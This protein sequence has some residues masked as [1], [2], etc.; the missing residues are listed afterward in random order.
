VPIVFD[1]TLGEEP[2]ALPT[3]PGAMPNTVGAL[4]TRPR[5]VR[6]PS[7]TT[8]SIAPERALLRQQAQDAVH[9]SWPGVVFTDGDVTEPTPAE[10]GIPGATTAPDEDGWVTLGQKPEKPEAPKV[11]APKE[12][13]G[14]F[15]NLL[16]KT[17]D[18]AGRV[19]SDMTIQTADTLGDYAPNLDAGLIIDSNGVHWA[20]G[21][22]YRDQSFVHGVASALRDPDYQFVDHE[23]HVKWEDI[24]AAK[25]NGDYGAMAK[26]AGLYAV[27]NGISSVPDM[28]AVL[29]N[30]PGYFLGLASRRT[31][32]RAQNAG[33]P[34]APNASDLAI[35]SST[36]IVETLLE[37]YGAE[38][39]FDMFK[40]PKSR[41][42]KWIEGT[43][44]ETFTEAAQ[45]TAEEIGTKVG[46]PKQ[47][48][49]A[50]HLGEVAAQNALGGFGGGATIGG[51]VQL[52]DK[53]FGPSEQDV[54][55]Q[56][57]PAQKTNTNPQAPAATGTPASQQ[58]A[59]PTT[60]AP[61]APASPQ[62]A[63]P[64]LQPGTVTLYQPEGASGATPVRIERI[65][66]KT[67]QAVVTSLDENGDP[68]IVDGEPATYVVQLADLG[69]PKTT[70][71][72]AAPQV[73]PAAP[74]A[75]AAPVAPPAAP[76]APTAAP[77][78]GPT[79][80]DG[81]P[82]V[83]SAEPLIDLKGQIA[84]M[85]DPNTPRK[86]VLLSKDNVD[87]LKKTKLLDQ[88]TAGTVPVVNFDYRGGTMLF[89][90]QATAEAAVAARDA[91]RKGT[92]IQQLIGQLTGA[93]INKPNAGTPTAV[94]QRVNPQ[95][96]VVQESVVPTGAVP[97]T[98]TAMAQPGHA[99]VVTTPEAALAR[100]AQG[101]AADNA[102]APTAPAP[103]APAPLKAKAP[104]A[105]HQAL[106]D[107]MA[108]TAS[109]EVPEANR[110]N[111]GS[112][113][114]RQAN[115]VG[116][117]LAVETALKHAVAAGVLSDEEV[118]AAQAAVHDIKAL[119]DKSTEATEKGQGT[120]HAKVTSKMKAL[121]ASAQT[122]AA[123][124][125][126]KQKEAETAPKKAD[127]KPP[128]AAAKKKKAAPKVEAETKAEEKAETE[129][130]DEDINVGGG[131]TRKLSDLART[132]ATA[133]SRG[134]LKASPHK[135]SSHL[136]VSFADAQKVLERAKTVTK[137]KKAEAKA[138]ETKKAVEAVKPDP[139]A[140]APTTITIAPRKV[141]GAELKAFLKEL[142]LDPEQI[143]ADAE[144][145][146]GSKRAA[147]GALARELEKYLPG[148]TKEGSW[149]QRMAG[150]RTTEDLTDAQKA[151]I[152]KAVKDFIGTEN[153]TEAM[154][155]LIN[156]MQ[157]LNLDMKTVEAIGQYAQFMKAFDKLREKTDESAD[158]DG[159]SAVR[160]I[161]YAGN[162][163]LDLDKP[164]HNIDEPLVGGIPRSVRNR[165][166]DYR[167]QLTRVLRGSSLAQNIMRNYMGRNRVMS[168]KELLRDLKNL[169]P[170]D[171]YFG[172]LISRLLKA[173]PDVPIRFTSPDVARGRAGGSYQPS[174]GTIIVNLQPLMK[175]GKAVSRTTQG[176]NSATEPEM[177]HF[178]IQTII[179]ELVHAATVNELRL[180]KEGPLAKKL[181]KLIEQIT[182]LA[183]EK[184]GTDV[185]A[186]NLM[187][188]S[189]LGPAPQ[190]F[191]RQLYGLSKPEE[192]VTEALTN[193]YFAAELHELGK[194][195]PQDRAAPHTPFLQ[196]I[197]RAIADFLGMKNPR[198]AWLLQDVLD[199]SSETMRQQYF[200]AQAETAQRA[201][202]KAEL[203]AAHK[204]MFG[205]TDE[206][207]KEYAEETARAPYGPTR[208]IDTAELYTM[209]AEALAD[210]AWGTLY[211]LQGNG[212]RSELENLQEEPIRR[213][214]EI[215]SLAGNTA[216]KI[217]RQMRAVGKTHTME[218]I[219]K[220][221][222]SLYTFDQIE[223]RMSRFFGTEGA[224]N[225]L[226]K[227]MDT[228]RTRQSHANTLMER[229]EK[230]V[231][232]K[233]LKLSQVHSTQVGQ[234][235]ID[236]TL[237]QIDPS[238]DKASQTERV[239]NRKDFDKRY[240]QL[241]AQWN[242]LNGAQREVYENARDYAT[243]TFNK[244]R[245]AAV[246]LAIDGMSDQELSPAQRSLLYSVRTAD[247]IDQLVGTGK[248]I[249][250][251]GDA[252][253]QF[254]SAL[255]DV[256]NLTKLDGP[257][258][259][260]RR[261]GDKVVEADKEGQDTYDTKDEALARQ[262]QIKSM[263]PANKAT[264][265][266]DGDKY[267]VKYKM[268]Y[269][270][271]HHSRAEA[272]ADAARLQ[273]MGFETGPV[274]EKT[275][276][277]DSTA[278]TPALK[279]LMANAKKKLGGTGEGVNAVNYALESA[280]TQILAERSA[281]MSGQLK[282]AGFVGTKASEM[283]KGFAERAQ[284]TAWHY[285]NM[286][287][288]KAEV[289]ALTALRKTARKDERGNADQA[290]MY[291]RGLAV[292][293]VERRISIEAQEFG[294]HGPIESLLGKLGFANYLLTP[295]YTLVNSMQNFTVAM[296]VVGAKYGY[297]K[298][299]RAFARAMAVAGGTAFSKAIRGTLR[300][301][302]Q[303]NS[304]DIFQALEE[305]LKNDP[306][307]GKYVKGENSAIRQLVD[308]GVINASFTQEL[309][310]VAEGDNRRVQQVMEWARL[311]PQ[312]A[313][314]MNRVSTALAM[315]EL[316]NGNVNKTA[317][318]IRLTHIDY[319]Q[320]NQPRAFRRIGK[321]SLPRALT[322]FKMYPQAIYNLFSSA[323]YD[324]LTGAGAPRA[325]AAKTLAG[326]TVSHTVAAGVLG[327]LM[328]EPLRWMIAGFHA[329][330]GDDDEEWDLDAMIRGWL[331]DTFGTKGGQVAAH[332]IFNALGID[333]SGRL[334]IN[335]LAFYSPPDFSSGDPNKWYQTVAEALGPI[336]SMMV[337]NLTA[338][339]K[340][341]EA[342]RY[343]DAFAAMVPVKAV[344][345]ANKAYN[346]V[347]EGIQTTSGASIVDPDKVG[348]ARAAAQLA[349]FR[350]SQETDVS[351]KRQAKFKYEDWLG[352]RKTQ[353]FNSYWSAKG[354]DRE[355]V[356]AEIKQFNAKNP[357][358]QITSG[359]L[360]RSRRS[361]LQQA[362][363]VNGE[364]MR[365]PDLKEKLDF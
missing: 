212:L 262:E 305:T 238:K 252:N 344:Q 275:T 41:L 162:D 164:L 160:G 74:P 178:V 349:G 39:V 159:P 323:V 280:F 180:N 233:W 353:L 287:T 277:T 8:E 226:T 257:Y 301:P 245:R 251:G 182:K 69:A 195:N 203:I 37:K 119:A 3:A 337:R 258:F 168:S 284:S 129:E 17:A 222:L 267:T 125:E 187:Y 111:A 73:N 62:G 21:K 214:A 64:T 179:H 261:H 9:E 134:D 242:S 122:I 228:R 273:G 38:K 322:M 118:K 265:V 75:A 358:S 102:Q 328:M 216:T 123:R 355:E 253:D 77:T 285:A 299:S 199:A 82:D 293:E 60:Q 224:D 302:G 244:V 348:F 205:S 294:I 76:G 249:D 281:S 50:G 54:V 339:N 113:Q 174:Q 48:F 220:G 70:A 42:R 243:H 312:A 11:E 341:R 237:W 28:I 27:E 260:L 155:T 171:N 330:F 189:R 232:A 29:Y 15:N 112:L 361:A 263:T 315:L 223:R 19:L 4:P 234:M 184:Y 52:L 92:A 213:E 295:S 47:D 126:A 116:F 298:T 44:A 128:V 209:G 85:A 143:Q 2:G 327:G 362:A 300:K 72:P 157:G 236:S 91:N 53:A 291:Q 352:K 354:A 169:I 12:K 90:D 282:R 1:E 130:E 165:I 227:L 313:E 139:A 347:T 86:G 292:N 109:Q 324:T 97:A 340:A 336:P 10:S 106:R 127:E 137:E 283:H 96:A 272:E 248:I 190:T 332:G 230:D 316:T 231:N 99:T 24:K 131:K 259:P 124:L 87:N 307:Y 274:T 170:E 246:D 365:N 359:S 278:L 114:T 329:A 215:R 198:E 217:A 196:K 156:K 221:F 140:P 138:T 343:R 320:S 364:M 68:L 33:R 14:F 271:F 83:P 218:K 363:Q 276:A 317:D 63:A 93:G 197:F 173:A 55:G 288:A 303:T 144:K 40:G 177:D 256:M 108:F 319:S 309:A 289:A 200:R 357:G 94:V 314:M 6:P 132:A 331:A 67:G 334:G 107:A 142:G 201:R 350:T 150:L 117:G 23:D 120:G 135:V 181:S 148:V 81:T 121:A 149:L 193:P 147:R 103:V 325:E 26:G 290:T 101:V 250:L 133:I 219:R 89:P 22:E 167:D 338:F 268:H 71:K 255:K 105:P 153:V 172:P 204:E 346:Q 154:D 225:V 321:V 32:E 95:G 145:E 51:G 141:E 264:V 235:M 98:A 163:D 31:Q 208:I 16:R 34:D 240:D 311:L 310:A 36:A 351:D 66:G 335:H 61:G 78:A 241:V 166:E 65:T 192:L 25:E 161:D 80:P 211:T 152:W 185:V 158:E 100:R 297:G 20:K 115:A 269:T 247:G 266:K 286:K 45:G 239:K 88:V 270:A 191:L 229:A 304:Y 30:A 18:D 210:K 206:R 254:K 183:E 13:R 136:D 104:V 43:L 202:V 46:T 79:S 360:M 5:L 151:T 7:V 146:G 308:L 326:L 279:E 57:A 58:P 175:D 318:M 176:L 194:A 207:A 35:G 110:K 186:Q 188:F 342:G 59:K 306:R 356:I 296:P 345:D 56:P 49:S 333:L 84:D